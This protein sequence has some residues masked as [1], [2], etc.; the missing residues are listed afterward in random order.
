MFLILMKTKPSLLLRSSHINPIQI[1]KKRGDK[2]NLVQVNYCISWYVILRS[3]K[4]YFET[5][6]HRQAARLDKMTSTW[7]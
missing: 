4:V 6:L 3:K 2:K 7:G 5:S 1:L